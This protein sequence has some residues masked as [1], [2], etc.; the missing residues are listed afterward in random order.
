MD[1][2]IYKKWKICP[3]DLRIVKQQLT[4]KQL[5]FVGLLVNYIGI[6]K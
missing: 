1:L 6:V 3:L 2:Y 4:A 5:L